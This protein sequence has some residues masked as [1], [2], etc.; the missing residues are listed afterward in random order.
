MFHTHTQMSS[1]SHQWCSYH[2]ERSEV[3]ATRKTNTPRSHSWMPSYNMVTAVSRVVHCRGQNDR[4]CAG[5]T[6]KQTHTHTHLLLY[7]G[8]SVIITNLI[9]KVRATLCR[10]VRAESFPPNISSFP[11]LLFNLQLL[12]PT[13]FPSSFLSPLPQLF[14]FSCT[15]LLFPPH[16]SVPFL[17]SPAFPTPLFSPISLFS[18]HL[19]LVTLLTSLFSP[20]CVCHHSLKKKSGLRHVKGRN[21]PASIAAGDRW[22]MSFPCCLCA[23]LPLPSNKGVPA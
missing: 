9:I 10:R 6:S 16:L 14:S 11:R 19:P 3:T 17:F 8:I 20:Q 22:W 7:L 12:P 15:T 4:V 23:S 13:P 18:N 2:L 1:L 21:V 5:A